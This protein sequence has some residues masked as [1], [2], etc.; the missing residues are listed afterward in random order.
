VLNSGSIGGKAVP[1][2]HVAHL[3]LLLL[4]SMV[5][6]HEL[7]EVHGLSLRQMEHICGYL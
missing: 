2:Q 6:S 5:L 3:V 4:Q 7:R 1:A